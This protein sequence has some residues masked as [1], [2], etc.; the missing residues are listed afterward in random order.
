M[1][2]GVAACIVILQ[3]LGLK[4][5]EIRLKSSIDA[6]YAKTLELFRYELRQREQ[7][8]IVAELI[9]EWGAMPSDRKRLNQLV[10]QASL[11]LPEDLARE[12]NRTLNYAKGHKSAKE[13]LILIRHLI[14]GEVDGLN[15]EELVY[16]D[17][18]DPPV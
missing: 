10:M 4:W 15:A 11:W 16:F 8:A 1:E 9:A 5:L 6:E 14:R 13:V 2:A 18:D 3:V 7:S 12:L 17:P